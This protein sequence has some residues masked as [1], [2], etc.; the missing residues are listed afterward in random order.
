MHQLKQ[1]R[2]KQSANNRLKRKEISPVHS[3]DSD[4][5]EGSSGVKRD[6]IKEI[7]ELNREKNSKLDLAS[8]TDSLETHQSNLGQDKKALDKQK[9]INSKQKSK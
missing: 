2:E 4:G 8:S 7:I 9:G 5:G 6:K 1:L 3:G